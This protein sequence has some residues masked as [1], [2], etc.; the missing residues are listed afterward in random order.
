MNTLALLA[1]RLQPRARILRLAAV[2][3]FTGIAIT[4]VV[5][6]RSAHPDNPVLHPVHAYETC[7]VAE[8]K[9]RRRELDID[10]GLMLRDTTQQ[11]AVAIAHAQYAAYTRAGDV[12]ARINLLLWLAANDPTISR[13]WVE[14]QRTLLLHEL[15]E[16]DSAPTIAA[17]CKGN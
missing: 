5:R 16:A 1:E 13:D 15:W 8:D 12:A 10:L 4:V 3:S 6:A 2:V 7:R 17:N 9:L 11:A 14:G